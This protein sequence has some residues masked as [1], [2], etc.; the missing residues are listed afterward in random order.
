M[1]VG[2]L[3]VDV[4]RKNIKHMHL[5][6]YPPNGR[7]RVAVPLRI[8]DEAVALAITTRLPWIHK[9][10]RK[11][12]GQGRQSAREYIPRES[13]YFKG[14]RYL[15]NLIEHQSPPKVVL[16]GKPSIDLYVRKGASRTKRERILQEWYRQELKTQIPPLIDKWQKIMNVSVLQWGVKR[17]KTRWGTCNVRARRI[18]INLEIAKKPLQCLDYII[19][20]EMAHLLERRHNPNFVAL[21]DKFLPNWKSLRQ[22]LNSY[23]LRHEAWKY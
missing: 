21:M 4:V 10:Q 14:R 11:F 8:N 17:M 19:V 20:H 13:H 22:T 15:L 12:V 23:P 2:E 3:L 16:T 6:V 18:W 9:H 7:V 1:R 5:A